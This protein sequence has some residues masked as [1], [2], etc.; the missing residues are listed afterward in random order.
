MDDTNDLARFC[1]QNPR[2]QRHGERGTGNLSVC[3]TFGKCDH[4]LLYCNVCGARFSEFKGTAL[5]NSKLPHET[6]LMI[7]KQLGE[8]L[9]RLSRP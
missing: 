9:G 5:F 8:G 2:C 1:C 6:V 4:R 7:L 3:G